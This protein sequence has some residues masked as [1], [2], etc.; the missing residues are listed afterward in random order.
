[1]SCAGSLGPSAEYPGQAW[2]P[3][4]PRPAHWGIPS[5]SSTGRR[6]GRIIGSN[7]IWRDNNSYDHSHPQDHRPHQRYVHSRRY[8]AGQSNQPNR[9]SYLWGVQHSSRHRN[10]HHKDMQADNSLLLGPDNSI[11]RQYVDQ[12]H[13]YRGRRHHWFATAHCYSDSAG[14]FRQ[15]AQ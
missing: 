1:L 14:K 8:G 11:Y 3:G 4:I 7:D 10:R 6:R 15:L 13:C 5:C 2:H 9:P 12:L